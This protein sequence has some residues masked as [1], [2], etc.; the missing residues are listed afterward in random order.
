MMEELGFG[1]VECKAAAMPVFMA[2]S[3]RKL[4][5]YLFVKPDDYTHEKV[6]ADAGPSLA[7]ATPF[8]ADLVRVCV[9]VC[10]CAC[11]LSSPTLWSRTSKAP[12]T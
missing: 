8:N 3:G 2:G 11:A 4:N 10:V 7:T 1:Q 9:C 6:P 12:C 5:A